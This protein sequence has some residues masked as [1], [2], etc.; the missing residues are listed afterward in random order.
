MRFWRLMWQRVFFEFCLLRLTNHVESNFSFI[1][2]SFG[3]WIGVK[4]L[5]CLSS[6]CK[7]A[8]LV[9]VNRTLCCLLQTTKTC[10]LALWILCQKLWNLW[11]NV[12]LSLKMLLFRRQFAALV[13]QLF[14]PESMHIHTMS[15]LTTKIVREPSG[16]DFLLTLKMNLVF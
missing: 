7:G 2:F 12:E 3:K 10:F 16:G 11:A 15:W 14:W 4:V 8:L 1:L 6:K 13:A 5:D 9:Q